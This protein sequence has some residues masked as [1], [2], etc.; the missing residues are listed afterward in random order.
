MSSNATGGVAELTTEL[1][2]LLTS[3]PNGLTQEK[4]QEMLPSRPS[5][6]SLVEVINKL[7][8]EGRLSISKRGSE[9]I[10]H[11]ANPEETAKFRGLGA[12]EMLIFQLIDREGNQGIWMR[13]LRIRSNLSTPQITKVIKT[14]ENRKL[15]KSV[16]SI[17]SKNKKVYMRYDLDPSREITGGA[18]Y[19]NAEFDSEFIQQLNDTCYIIIC[20]KGFM[21]VEEVATELRKTNITRV[22]LNLDDIQMILDTLIYDGKVEEIQLKGRRAYKPS[23]LSI[24][25]NGYTTIP[26]GMCPVASLCSDE[27]DITPLKCKY[28]KA[29]L[30][31]NSF[32]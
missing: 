27:G 16:T 32:D 5:L 28:Y 20:K 9:F 30:E 17:N 13:E 2:A 6:E 10:Y 24:P 7:L 15:I 8:F 14:L 19:T 31:Y 26:C 11:L 1:I 3:H 4:V 29:W 21:T 22:E 12:E 25:K 18:W 23:K